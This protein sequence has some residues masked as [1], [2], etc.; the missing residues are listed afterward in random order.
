MEQK[1]IYHCSVCSKRAKLGFREAQL[2]GWYWVRR[3]GIW[4]D[5]Y[6]PSCA[7]AFRGIRNRVNQTTAWAR[8]VALGRS[9]GEGQP[10]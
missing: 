1:R 3:V 7:L 8:L 6:R 4:Y 9:N 10:V 2:A 5:Y